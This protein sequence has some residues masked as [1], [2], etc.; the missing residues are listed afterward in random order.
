M[1]ANVEAVSPETVHAVQQSNERCGIR[2]G[3]YTAIMQGVGENYFTAFGLLLRASTAQ[4]G[5]LTALPAF[6]G[7]F[8]QL[9]SIFWLRWFDRRQHVVVAAA[10]A[11]A[12]LWIPLLALPLLF[13]AYGVSVLIACAIPFVVAGHFA[14]PAWN[15]LITDLIDPVRRGAY[16]A[17]R[18]RIMS[19]TSFGSLIAAGVLLTWTAELHR[20]WVGFAVVFLVA[21]YARGMAALYLRRLDDTQAAGPKT[22][23]LGLKGFRD[24][25][26]RPFFKFLLFSGTINF[27]AMVAGPYIAVYVLRDLGFSYVLYSAW[28]GASVMG[29]YMALNAWGRI[30][31]CYGNK[32][33]LFASGVGLPVIPALYLFTKDVGWIIVINGV[34]GLMWSGFHL[35]LQNIV[36][37]LAESQAR[38][39]AVAISN[40]VNATGAFLGTMAGGWLSTQAPTTFTIADIGVHFPS[41]LPMVFLASALCLLASLFLIR[42]FKEARIVEPISHHALFL[43]LPL[44]KPMMDVL[45]SRIGHQP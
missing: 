45:G 15:S 35:G 22:R 26:H 40:G 4:I 2:E 18:A 25:Q 7:T 32:K 16:F 14:I 36:Y 37:D 44:I 1:F 39:G 29:G 30:G 19:V 24:P 8:A 43:E 38:A 13:P 23:D 34:A 27:G 10:Y 5:L 11:Q 12:L 3:A 17:R 21:A 20:P 31:D 28:A 6:L 9:A 33:L 41:N 42:L